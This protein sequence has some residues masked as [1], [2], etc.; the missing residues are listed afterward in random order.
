MVYTGHLNCSQGWNYFTL[1][2]PYHYDGSGN[3]LIIVDDNSGAYDGSSYTFKTESCS[4]TKTIYY[5]SDSNN[6]DATN[7]ST[8]SG[9]MGTA[10][11]RPVMQL[12]SCAADACSQPT[13]TSVSKDY[14][15]A[16]TTWLGDGTLLLGN[17]DK[18]RL[19]IRYSLTEGITGRTEIQE[20]IKDISDLCYDPVRKALWIAD[21]ELR[22]INLCTLEGK[23]LATYP[24]PF[25]DNGEGLCVDHARQCIWVGD[26]TTNKLYRIQFDQL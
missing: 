25:I 19:L 4:G 5:Y 20:G 17:Q 13:I 18:P 9:N 21:S 24:V 3:L 16:T 2:T 14:Q 6:P 8:F 11:W 7:P 23:V 26:D 12:V 22:T 1:S 10:S 15:S